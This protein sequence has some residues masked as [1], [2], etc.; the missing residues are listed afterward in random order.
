MRGI[1]A[2]LPGW[3]WP[4]WLLALLLS[5][6]LASLLGLVSWQPFRDAVE[7]LAWYPDAVG[8]AETWTGRTHEAVFIVFAVLLLA[9]LAVLLAL[10]LGGLV[11][12]VI[13]A[14]VEPTAQ[15]AGIPLWVPRVAV[16]GSLLGLAVAYQPLWWP[17]LRWG[18]AVVAV[19]VLSASR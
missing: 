3:R 9:T 6:A 16:V 10:L 2:P 1:P 5:V 15:R 12:L 17:P 13:S 7:W 4:Q 19:A 18:L 11:V 8:P 14:A